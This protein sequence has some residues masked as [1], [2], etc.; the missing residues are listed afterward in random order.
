MGGAVDLKALELFGG[1]RLRFSPN[2]RITLHPHLNARDVRIH[3]EA[4]DP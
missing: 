4:V 3:S 2:A 1:G